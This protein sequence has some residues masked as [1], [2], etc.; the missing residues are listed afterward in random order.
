MKWVTVRGQAFWEPKV[1]Q[2]NV[3]GNRKGKM[4][5]ERR[6]KYDGFYT[7]TCGISSYLTICAA[8]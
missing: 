1:P 4:M 5:E 3:D 8:P 7:A 6:K 2:K